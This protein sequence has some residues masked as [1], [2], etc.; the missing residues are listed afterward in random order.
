MKGLQSFDLF[1]KVSVENV[2]KPTLTG[3]IISISAIILIFILIIQELRDYFSPSIKK[4]SVILQD[5]Q[6]QA[7]ID[8]NFSLK[9]YNIPCAMLSMDQ[10]DLIGAHKLDIKNTITKTRMDK[11]NEKIL[12]SYIPYK[13]DLMEKSILA[14][15]SCFINGHLPIG[16]APGDIHLSFHPYREVYDFLTRTESKVKDKFSLSHR[17]L[18]LNF[19]DKKLNEKIVSIFGENE[20]TQL[21]SSSRDHMVDY[22]N[23]DTQYIPSDPNSIQKFNYDYYIKL[24]PHIFYHES[25]D[26]EYEAYQFAISFKS[27]PTE[28]D[29]MPIIMINYDHSPITM[30]ITLKK[31]YISTFLIHICAIIGGV[32]AMFSI[33]NRI[34]LNL[35]EGFKLTDKN[36]IK[37]DRKVEFVDSSNS[38]NIPGNR[39]SSFYPN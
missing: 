32:Y 21:L 4:D 29:E 12:G 39:N 23:F 1:Q 37:E 27:R 25:K 35:V 31:K 10:E 30:K 3:S 19:G 13:T 8:M 7:T 5:N 24:I 16:K 9:L 2:V 14:G 38:I 22:P 15:E 6:D 20:H 33:L 18:F 36:Y 26:E 17:F 34:L 11:N 28:E